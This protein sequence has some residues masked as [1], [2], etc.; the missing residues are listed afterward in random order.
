MCFGE[1]KYGGT[2]CVG[3]WIMKLMCILLI[4]HM[5]VLHVC[6]LMSY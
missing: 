6:C 3:E 2:D 5:D 1:W 4:G